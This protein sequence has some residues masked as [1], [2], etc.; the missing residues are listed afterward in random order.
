MPATRI[1]VTSDAE[2]LRRL[3]DRLPVAAAVVDGER[4]IANARVEAITGRAPGETTTL[5]AWLRALHGDRADAA[6]AE[7]EADRALGFPSPRTIELR[8]GDGGRRRV[9][10]A[11][12]ET[13]GVVVWTVLDVTEREATAAA[14]GESQRSLATLLAHL[15]GMAYRCVN[16]AH[17]TMLVVSAGCR[18]LTG[19]DPEELVG[20][21][22]VSYEELIVPEDRAA[23]RAE[24]ESALAGGRP[25][26]LTY[27]LATAAGERKWV[28]ESGQGV[29]CEAGGL[30]VEGFVQDVTAQVRAEEALRAS[31]TRLRGF[32]DAP[33][34]YFCLFDLDEAGDD[35]VFAMPNGAFA[36]AYGLT[37]EALAGRR[38]RDLR[39]PP[40]AVA[41]WLDALRRCRES[42]EPLTLE[43]HPAGTVRPIWVLANLNRVGGNADGRALVACVATDITERK[44][45]EEQFRQAQ[46]MEAV[47][48]LAGGVAHDFNNL[49]T[50][51]GGSAEFLLAACPP[52][53]PRRD[54]VLEIGRAAER[55][56]DLTRQLLA[57][58]RRQA[59]EP[60]RLDL[61][62][63]VADAERMLGRLIGED[64]ALATS[65]AP[66]APAVHADPGHVEQA[67]VN[68]VV[69]ARDA[70][71]GGGRLEVGTARAVVAAGDV[72]GLAP[73]EY[74]VLSVRDSGVGMDAATRARIFEPFFTTKEPGKGTGLG[75]STVF[76][77]VTQAG[78]HVAVESAPGAG[79]TFRL[80]LPAAAADA[81]PESP[82]P[83]AAPGAG[84]ETV[85]VVEDEPQVRRLARRALERRGYTV[86]EAADGAEA[87]AV[88]DGRHARIDLVLADAVLPELGGR[89]V[90][91]ALRAR[92][93]GIAALFMSGYGEDAVL[94]Q[95][96][97]T[98]GAP[99]VPK[100]FTADQLAAAVRA[101]LDAGTP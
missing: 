29:P 40:D 77:I 35:F 84:T 16:D 12:R 80:Y 5:D 41:R 94:R 76:G 93:P 78:G 75:L 20:N 97:A 101:A 13:E 71:P 32:F 4:V 48:R 17:W 100:P 38:G 6:R 89:A 63:L 36:A 43:L 22:R 56:R 60:R 28:R 88:S 58:G 79:T 9:E 69:N 73:G 86:L 54:D 39:L 44:M 3:V 98:E 70:M 47:G 68:L 51:I 66:D 62:A 24:T 15:P 10:L 85:L 18:A 91:D 95:H 42:G 26:E 96:V 23:V 31:E 90:V 7:Y 64:V 99:F 55:A 72:G 59:V 14:L 61:N 49:L 1:D 74:A 53:D 33:S 37:P 65:L 52:G 25:F 81:A 92:R 50:V 27:R 19:Y 87:L 67:L 21:R 57:F 30:A 83:A 2:E 46:K 45:L 82:P 11:A 8:R 34:V